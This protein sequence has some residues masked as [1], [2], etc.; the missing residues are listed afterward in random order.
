MDMPGETKRGLMPHS[1]GSPQQNTRRNTMKSVKKKKN[2]NLECDEEKFVI[3][4]EVR[5]D[6][7]KLAV[8][9][10]GGRKAVLEES[11]RPL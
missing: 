5:V 9:E 6:F 11:R 2:T 10:G 1:G 8:E 3:E 7:M 4:G